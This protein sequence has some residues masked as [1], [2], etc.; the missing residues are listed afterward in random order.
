MFTRQRLRER[1]VTSHDGVIGESVYKGVQM[2]PDGAGKARL[3]HII[4]QDKIQFFF[5]EKLGK[6]S[7]QGN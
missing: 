4:R 7:E 6:C 2:A 3:D 5:L 1:N